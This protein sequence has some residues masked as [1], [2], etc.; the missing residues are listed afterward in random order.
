MKEVTIRLLETDPQMTPAKSLEE[1]VCWEAAQD[2]ESSVLP[3][4]GASNFDRSDST[5]N[6]YSSDYSC[7]KEAKRDNWRYRPVNSAKRLKTVNS[8]QTCNVFSEQSSDGEL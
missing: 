8:T 4:D 1:A 7:Q 2:L 3:V 5:D 6:D